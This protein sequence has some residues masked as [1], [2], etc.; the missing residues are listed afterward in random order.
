MEVRHRARR[1]AAAVACALL[2]AACGGETGSANE[3]SPPPVDETAYSPGAAGIGDRYFPTAGNGGYDVDR[4]ELD[5]T[6]E[7]AERRLAGSAIVLATTTANLSSF[8]L[9][10]VGLTVDS[11]EVDGAA[12][13]W[14]RSDGELTVTPQR[15]L[16]T[17]SPFRTVI[18]YHG[19]P[20]EL[21]SDAGPLK[22]LV[23][24][25]HGA[26]IAGQPEVAA[27]WF[28]VNDHPRDRAA[29]RVR[30]SV[31][32]GLAAIS[33]GRL[34]EQSTAA[35]RSVWTWEAVEPM[36]PYLATL[37]VGTFEVTDYRRGPIDYWDA[38]DTGL[39]R[40]F[41]PATGR[42]FLLGAG[43]AR[44][45]RRIVRTI[46]VPA[47]GATVSFEVDRFTHRN[48]DYVLVEARTPGRN[49][50]TTL[51]DV[52]GHTTRDAGFGCAARLEVHP[53]LRRYLTPKDDG[54]CTA[55]GTTGAW[56]AATGNSEGYERWSV[57]LG[58]WAGASVEVAISHVDVGTSTFPGVAVD[59]IVVAEA[60]GSTS[61]EDG[62][63][64]GWR[65][66]AVPGAGLDAGAIWVPRTGR[67]KPT[68]VA[69]ALRRGL[70]RQDEILEFLASRFGP[71]PFSTAGAI[72]HSAPV[73][74][75]L[76]TQTRS[77]Y[78]GASF[79]RQEDFERIVVH[80]IAH[81]WFG[82]SLA[83]R[84]WQHIWL[85]E[86]FATYA[87]WLWFEREGTA[88][89][90]ESFQRAYDLFTARDLWKNR[91]GDPGPD[92]LFDSSYQR[93]AMTLHQIR[94]SIGDAKFFRLL[95]EWP[96][97]YAG[98]T[99][100]TDA[101]RKLAEEI[102]GRDLTELFRRWLFTARQPP[103]DTP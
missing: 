19:T 51:P 29:F 103:A 20:V 9:D 98:K 11:V 48:N 7:P 80:E 10:L 44:A 62:D 27:T 23:P 100:T 102:G 15:G 77:V 33:N 91:T 84:A 38:V 5:L 94:R 61:F 54:Q 81:Q 76:E 65:L 18:R 85:N 26:L 49:D 37:A 40:S 95:K 97:R 52:N 43:Q 96:T 70:A 34:L 35:G 14:T 39:L 87:E 45:H 55:K 74:F 31:P 71:Y 4:Y 50:W 99:V 1:T 75:A 92:A 16:R 68:A 69:T 12:A 28:P 83:L 63:R 90:E 78:P 25:R 42:D 72:V 21:D 53:F 79:V 24:T 89:V 66:A 60:A 17:D 2:L 36:A 22:R 41:A 58:A 13:Q 64:G 82:D 56:H 73:G 30:V 86:G 93:G 57:D 59:D 88:T 47:R 6:Y 46:A 8:N 67:Q 3:P 101:F 32:A